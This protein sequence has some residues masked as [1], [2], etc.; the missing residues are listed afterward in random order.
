M[1][2][3]LLLA[4]EINRTPPKTQAALL[5]AMQERTVSYAGTTHPLPRAVLRAG[6]A[7][8]DRAGRHLSAARG[9]AR[10]LPAAHP[11]RLSDAR[12]R[13]ATILAQTTGAHARA[14]AAGHGRRRGARAAGARARGARRRRPA[15][16]DHAPGPRDAARRRRAA[17]KCANGCAGAPVRAPASRWCWRRRRAR[18]CTAASPRRAR[19]SRALAAPVLRHRLLLSFAAEAEQ[20]THRR[21]DRRPAAHAC[22]S[23]APERVATALH[24][25]SSSRPTCAAR[26]RD[27]RLAARAPSA[28]HGHRRSM[29]AAAAARA[30]SSRSTAPTSRATSRATSTGS[31]TRARIAIFVREAERDSPLDGVAADRR[32]RV[33][34]AGRRRAARMVEARRRES[35]RRVRD[36]AGA[37]PGRS[38]RLIVTIGGDGVRDCPGG[39]RPAP[40]R[41]LPAATCIGCR[42]RAAGPDAARLRAVVGTHRPG[43]TGA[44]AQR[45]LRR[46]AASSS[47]SGSRRRAARC[48]PSRC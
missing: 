37:A 19:T 32:H 26:L 3:N 44:A 13:S 6:D 20:R 22:R 31:C 34:G 39:G 40:A 41:P 42:P 2:T 8:P 1:F 16:L 14:G 28:Q 7:E 46:H 12:P 10:S 9:A 5:E 25:A 24:L 43:R 36:R 47:P 29:P 33:D 18:C 15:R 35:A 48:S 45:R 23:P 30:S 11:R 4:D 17:P 27:L 21:R 38:L